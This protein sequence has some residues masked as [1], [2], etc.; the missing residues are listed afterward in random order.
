VFLK[1][2]MIAMLAFGVLGNPAFSKE[3]GRN[4]T[5]GSKRITKSVKNLLKEGTLNSSETC[6][7]EYMNRHRQLVKMLGLG[8]LGG[9]AGTTGTAAAGVGA[10]AVSGFLIGSPM[11][12]AGLGGVVGG[13]VGVAGLV[14]YQVYSLTALLQNRYLIKVIS[15]ARDGEGKSLKRFTRSVSRKLKGQ[16]ISQESVAE[17]IIEADKSGA[18]CDGSLVRKSKKRKLTKLRHHLVNKRELI[19]HLKI[20]L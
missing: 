19:K 13:A 7:D 6:L 15:N 20:T 16:R 12:L 10:G 9:L 18:L 8:P 2:I 1:K 3:Q 4:F 17:L 5:I 14:G 11:V